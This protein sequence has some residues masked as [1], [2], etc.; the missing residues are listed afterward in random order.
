[1]QH[2]NSSSN[3]GGGGGGYGYI[4]WSLIAC[5]IIHTN[6]ALMIWKVSMQCS[7]KTRLISLIDQ[8][9]QITFILPCVLYNN[10]HVN[11]PTRVRNSWVSKTL[12]LPKTPVC[13]IRIHTYMDIKRQHLNVQVLTSLANIVPMA[14]I[15]T[16]TKKKKKKKEIKC[17]I[18]EKLEVSSFNRKKKLIKTMP[19]FTSHCVVVSY[20]LNFH[21]T[22]V[23]FVNLKA[24]LM[25]SRTL[26]NFLQI[27]AILQNQLSDNNVTMY[28]NKYKH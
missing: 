27:P 12:Q 15:T 13:G 16:T 19:C 17:Y 5:T 24:V 14:I 1:M 2:S 3:S 21:A 9:V 20:E 26:S 28:I 4:G 25:N 11:T 18:K 6:T 7:P 23:S 8:A 10:T 22:V